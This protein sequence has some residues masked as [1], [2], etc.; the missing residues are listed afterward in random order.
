M[1]WAGVVDGGSSRARR[2][3]RRAATLTAAALVAVA[4]AGL[5][6][7]SSPAGATSATTFGSNLAAAPNV[8]FGC[9]QLPTV[10]GGFINTGATQ[11]IWSQVSNGT[12]PTG[13]DI[14]PLGTGVLT[15][16]AVRVGSVTGKMQ[17][18]MIR[19]LVNTENLNTS[20]CVVLLTSPTFTPAPNAVTTQVVNFPIVKN[21]VVNNHIEV[22]DIL[23]LRVL[24]ANTPIPLTNETSKPINLQPADVALF[25]PFTKGV[26]ELFSDPRGYQLDIRGTYV[27]S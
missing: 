11:C 5:V 17:F 23:A 4:A 10:T 24:S 13:F 26:S 6:G 1:R 21:G 14:I 12:T 22:A 2:G 25:G 8:K 20:C 27:P 16:A 18:V 3:R 19:A 15:K 9:G 7:V